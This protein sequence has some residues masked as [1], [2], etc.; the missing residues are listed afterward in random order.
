V[1]H[2]AKFFGLIFLGLF[3]LVG[4][5]MSQKTSAAISSQPSSKVKA[6]TIDHKNSNKA[7]K[8]STSN[9]SDITNL[10]NAQWEQKL[11]KTNFMGPSDGPYPTLHKGENIWIDANVSKERIYIKDGNKTIYTMLTSSGLDTNPDTS[12]PTG[13]YYVQAEKGL[14]FYAPSEK[15]G[16]K[17]YTSWKNHGE[18]LFHTIPTDKNGNYIKSEAEK[19]GQKASH[20]CF[21]LPVLDAKWI[22]D[23]IPE[24]TKV[25]V[26]A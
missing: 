10:T 20:G 17:Y 7:S 6:S 4:C 1:R 26:H 14:S 23:N 16:A 9:S 13:T 2:K 15:E 21:R 12:T 24:G 5:G 18:F 11:A 8:S 22:Y 25:V 19:L 3:V